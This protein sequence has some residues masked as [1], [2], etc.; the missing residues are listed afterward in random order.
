[1]K[2]KSV[3]KY[4]GGGIIGGAIIEKKSLMR[5]HWKENHLEGIWK[6]SGR[7]PGGIWDAKNFECIMGKL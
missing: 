7:H 2:E 5:N 4:H 3:T 6:A 1:M